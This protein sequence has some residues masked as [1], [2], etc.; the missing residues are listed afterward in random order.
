[1]G[2]SPRHVRGVEELN[3]EVGLY[4]ES[5]FVETPM[6]PFD[7]L[8]LNPGRSGGESRNP[9]CPDCGDPIRPHANQHQRE[10]V[11]GCDTVRQFEFGVANDGG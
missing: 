1:M 9:L 8:V 3:A 4:E 11:C 6:D 10:F 2:D 5:S 7:P